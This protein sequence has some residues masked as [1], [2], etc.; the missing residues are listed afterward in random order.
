MTKTLILGLL[1]LAALPVA[2]HD[3]WIEPTAL[4]PAP[5]AQLGVRL[6]VGENF[7]GDPVPRDPARI[8]RFAIVGPNGEKPVPGVRGGEPAGYATVGPA[9]IYQIVYDSNRASVSLEP[10][11]FEDYLRLEG[12]ERIIELRKKHSESDKPSREVYSRCVKA[13][14]AVGGTS[15]TGFDKALGLELELIAEKNPF[16]IE[17]GGDLPVRLLYRGKP[18]AGALVVALPHSQP[19]TGALNARTDAQGRVR[20]KLPAGPAGAE[21]WL[22]KAVHMIE[23]P[24]D[25]QD[26]DWESFWASLVFRSG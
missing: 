1:L 21:I 22:I 16:E 12:L 2:A 6:R 5:G 3:F 13:L 26:A 7:V 18:L 19:E 8:E 10:K 9:G 4:T 14:L 23:A 20:F 11:K 17:P 25:A 24:K 15:G